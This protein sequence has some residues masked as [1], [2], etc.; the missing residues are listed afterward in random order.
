MIDYADLMTKAERLRKQFGEDNNSPIDIFSLAQGI[1]TLTIVYYPLGNKI[2]G[3]CIKGTE[4]RCTIALNS[5][6]TLGRQRFSLAHEFYHLFYD[7]NMKSVCAKSIGTGNETE[8]MADAFDIP[9]FSGYGIWKLS[10]PS[11]SY[12]DLDSG[13]I[14]CR[15]P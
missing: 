4:E 10:I 15:Q 6:M 9:S 14:W 11:S 8:K 3:M 13:C 12:R 2:S 7:N 5:S 1:E